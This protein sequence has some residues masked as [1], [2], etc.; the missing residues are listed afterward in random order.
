[1]SAYVRVATR[2]GGSSVCGFITLVVYFVRANSYF[3]DEGG[4]G[5]PQYFG[6]RP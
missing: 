2:G 3:K 5:T 6:Q 4:E 1:M